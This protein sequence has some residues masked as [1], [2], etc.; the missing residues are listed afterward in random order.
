MTQIDFELAG[1]TDGQSVADIADT[2]DRQK[3]EDVTETVK[4]C[5]SDCKMLLSWEGQV[6]FRAAWKGRPLFFSG[7]T[8]MPQAR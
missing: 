5:G 1:N 7:K 4:L 8:G 6:N 3:T 2:E